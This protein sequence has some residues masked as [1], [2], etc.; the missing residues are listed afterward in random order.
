VVTEH[1]NHPSLAMGTPALLIA[2]LAARTPGIR[3]GSGGVML[4]SHAPL[5]VAEEFSLLAAVH[6][7]RIDLGVG[8]GPGTDQAAARCTVRTRVNFL[9]R[10]P[11]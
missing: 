9:P 1:H 4:P 8:R 5:T 10:S 7:G 2:H 6:T 3:I 11:S